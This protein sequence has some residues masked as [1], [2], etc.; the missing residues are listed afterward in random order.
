LKTPSQGKIPIL[1]RNFAPE[2][3]PR[4]EIICNSGTASVPYSYYL[5]VTDDP[6]L[7]SWQ[8]QD[9]FLVS[10]RPDWV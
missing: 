6:G 5:C 2:N 3:L 10:E 7:E 1:F 8:G 9:I 4:Y